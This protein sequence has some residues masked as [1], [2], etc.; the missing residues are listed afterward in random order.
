MRQFHLAPPHVPPFRHLYNLRETRPGQPFGDKYFWKWRTRACRNLG[1]EG[2]DLYGGT[3][4]SSATALQ[5]H[6]SPEEIKE[7]AMHGTNSAFQRYFRTDIRKLQAVY[8]RASEGKGE[9]ARLEKW[10]CGGG[11]NIYPALH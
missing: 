4:H 9:K 3:R 10:S 1:I 7:A 11:I 8:E 6:F 5:A 2:M